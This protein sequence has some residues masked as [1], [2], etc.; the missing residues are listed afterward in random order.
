MKNLAFIRTYS[1]ERWIFYQFS[2]VH[3]LY[4]FPQKVRRTYIIYLE[5][6][7]YDSW[8]SLN[9]WYEIQ[10]QQQQNIQNMNT[11]HLVH[12]SA[13]QLRLVWIRILVCFRSDCQFLILM[14]ILLE[15]GGFF[16]WDAAVY[17]QGIADLF[18]A[19]CLKQQQNQTVGDYSINHGVPVVV[20]PY[21]PVVECQVW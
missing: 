8:F 3:D 12:R 1:D 2:L 21:F 4:I 20:L 18:V 11:M 5:V 19:A 10:Q 14:I 15:Y 6:K 7:G 16:P 13:A 9:E 17:K